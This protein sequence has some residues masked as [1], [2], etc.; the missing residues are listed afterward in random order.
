MNQKTKSL[1]KALEQTSGLYWN[2]PRE[3]GQFLNLLIKECKYKTVLEIGTSNGYSG[4]WLAEALKS[5]KGRLYTIESHK[6]A[7]YYLAQK[8]F[9]ESEL[10]KCITQI[11]GHAPQIIPPTP[12]YFDM[13]FFDATKE[14]YLSYFNA[15]KNRIKKGGVIAADN[16]CSHRN[17]LQDFLKK[18]KS[19]KNWLSFELPLGGGLLL[20]FKIH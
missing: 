8:N 18:I 10:S 5:T 16:V 2:I 4:I 11:L 12:R 7:R 17:Q 20:S 6:K 3:T 1:L 15:I 19:D 14:E 9:K 13:A